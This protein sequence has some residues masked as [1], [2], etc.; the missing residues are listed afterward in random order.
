VSFAE[1]DELE[2][3]CRQENEANP[4]EKKNLAEKRD[5]VPSNHIW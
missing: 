4:V 2:K 3:H 1:L 5:A